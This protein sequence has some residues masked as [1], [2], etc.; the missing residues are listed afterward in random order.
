MAVDPV[1]HAVYVTNN[2]DK[3]LSVID[4]SR[5]NVRTTLDVGTHPSGVA[6]DPVTH[7]VYI[8]NR[9]DDSVTVLKPR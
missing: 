7:T 9:D 8:A 1:T 5:H 3:T 6:V 4:G 2:G